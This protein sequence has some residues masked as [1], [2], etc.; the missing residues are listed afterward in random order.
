MEHSIDTKDVPPVSTSL[1]R[2][3][4]ALRDELEKELDNL[5]KSGCIE[6]SNSPYTSALV[7][8]RK[9]EGG[10]QICVNY[11][12]LNRD[13][14][15]DKYLI[16]RIDELIDRVGACKAKVF[17]ALDLM[18]GY[19]QVKVREEDKH[20]TAFVCH[21]GLY[22]YR[23]MP[24]GLTNAPATFQ[25]LI[26]KVFNKTDW[27]F[28]FTY[29]DDI[30]IASKSMEEHFDHIAAV[31]TKISEVGLRLQPG[32]CCLARTEIEYLGHT[33]TSAGVRPNNTKVEAVKKFPQS[34][35]AQDI[36]A[37]LV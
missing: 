16:P 21:Q 35:L 25:R 12:A 26:D 28:V 9:K 11:R 7:L 33:L 19:H 23:R 13:T 3:P 32:K 34:K 20:K 1:G 18:K 36:K 27:P 17:S 24:F 10:L 14:V 30:L 8:V 6:E 31:L 29:L 37:S 5:Q 4:Y 22:Q 2:I 15:L